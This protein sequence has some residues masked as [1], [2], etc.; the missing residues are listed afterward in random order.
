MKKFLLF[1]ILVVTLSS[2]I[3]PLS[4]KTINKPDVYEFSKVP[5]IDICLN[6]IKTNFE[7]FNNKLERTYYNEY[8]PKD[9]ISD[10]YQV[11][12][13]YLKY[14]VDDI[15][16]TFKEKNYLKEDGCKLTYNAYIHVTDIKFVR[17]VLKMEIAFILVGVDSQN[18][19]YRFEKSFIFNWNDVCKD[20]N[21]CLDKT[22]EKD[23]TYFANYSLQTIAKTFADNLKVDIFS[24]MANK[25]FRVTNGIIVDED[26]VEVSENYFKKDEAE[27]TV[28][29]EKK[30]PKENQT[31]M[32]K[33]I[34]K[35]FEMDKD[36]KDILRSGL[37]DKLTETG[38]SIISEKAQ[39]EA[40]KEQS[41]Q[42]KKECY[43]EECIVD[44]GKMIAARF[45]CLVDIKKTKNN[46]NYV[47]QL[48][49]IDIQSGETIKSRTNIYKQN[50]SD[51]ENIL[52]FAKKS[53]AELLN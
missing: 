33:V 2:C 11:D 29:S 27:T 40:L 38:Y 30:I 41:E 6:D 43:D 32:L 49:F 42:R 36:E 13:L 20:E 5:K 50:I 48:K 1:V 9:T 51:I 47:F 18:E 26:G 21:K 24:K 16:Q 19:Y 44:V 4:V 14:I 23:I 34:T 45:L 46:E 3:K 52:L 39:E 37:E 17:A 12:V 53:I 28:L 10:Y 35:E 25:N 22:K 8:F 15:K 31:V 7:Y